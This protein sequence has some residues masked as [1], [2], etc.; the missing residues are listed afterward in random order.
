MVDLTGDQ[1]ALL[2]EIGCPPLAFPA[3][4]GAALALATCSAPRTPPLLHAL[5]PPEADSGSRA[6]RGDPPACDLLLPEWHSAAAALARAQV[7]P[8]ALASG[9]VWYVHRGGWSPMPPRVGWAVA[10]AHFLR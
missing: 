10:L 7:V 3:S 5:F 1:L 8:L 2:L 9:F 4:P 6:W